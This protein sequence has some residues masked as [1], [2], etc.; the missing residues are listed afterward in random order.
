MSY[1]W[2]VYAGTQ[3]NIN[4]YC[5]FSE[6]VAMFNQFLDTSGKIVVLMTVYIV[7]LSISDALLTY[8]KYTYNSKCPD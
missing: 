7:E 1:V 5:C 8:K 2:L 3:P 4:I 6:D